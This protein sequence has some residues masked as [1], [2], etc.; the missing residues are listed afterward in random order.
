MSIKIWFKEFFELD[1]CRFRKTCEL[2]DRQASA[3]NNIGI[4][5]PLCGG[6]Y[7]GKYRELREDEGQ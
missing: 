5:M 3:C 6:I 4:R 7:C 2:Y 1:R